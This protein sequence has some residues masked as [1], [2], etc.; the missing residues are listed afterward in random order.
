MCVIFA[1][2]QHKASHYRRVGK[3]VGNIESQTR[4]MP[5]FYSRIALLRQFVILQHHRHLPEH[6]NVDAGYACHQADR[7]EESI[8]SRLAVFASLVSTGSVGR[9]NSQPPPST[10]PPRRHPTPASPQRACATPWWHMTSSMA[11]PSSICHFPQSRAHFHL[12]VSS[13]LQERTVD[14][15]SWSPDSCKI[16]AESISAQWVRE[17]SRSLASNLWKKQFVIVLQLVKKK[18]KNGEPLWIFFFYTKRT[19]YQM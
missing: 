9:A 13:K 4:E 11:L 3:S 6:C 14:A 18:K 10:I 19:E 12:R 17:R 2:L 7:W 1:N 8:G 5:L 15:S 16:H